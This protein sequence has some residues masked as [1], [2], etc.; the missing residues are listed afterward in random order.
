MVQ[1][2]GDHDGRDTR[3]LWRHVFRLA[4]NAHIS[5]FA[6]DN[7]S[8][9]KRLLII[10]LALVLASPAVADI[11]PPG[12]HTASPKFW[13]TAHRW[14][15]NFSPFAFDGPVTG[16]ISDRSGGAWFGLGQTVEHISSFGAVQNYTITKQWL[17]QVW[18]LARDPSGRIWFSLG[19]SG[20]IGTLD[21]YGRAY[22]LV[23]VARRFNPDIRKIVFA[24]N[25]DLWF[26]DYGRASI[27]RR[28]S[29]GSVKEIPTANGAWP[30]DIEFCNGRMWAVTQG[31]AHDAI[32]RIDGNLDSVFRFHDWKRYGE[33]SLACDAGGRLWYSH[34]S[35]YRTYSR[36]GYIDRDGGTYEA[37]AML[38]DERVF[39]APDRG[40]VWFSGFRSFAPTAYDRARLTLLERNGKGQTVNDMTLPIPWPVFSGT[41][42][43]AR[44]G[45][46]WLGIWY[47][48]SVVR[49]SHFR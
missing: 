45:T 25:G 29:D 8:L 32:Y 49:L 33:S 3:S 12:Q 23:V 19:Q 43:A 30:I 41:L 28:S 39:S 31:N 22:T 13:K 5:S 18:S 6:F 14:V 27:G 34:F 36:Q 44:D 37:A 42:T 7:E 21:K 1:Y 40:T 10:A 24:P 46:V 47:P 4:A 11:P 2:V 26:Q 17:W 38:Q 16:L 35:A 20:R 15:T 48:H 9:V